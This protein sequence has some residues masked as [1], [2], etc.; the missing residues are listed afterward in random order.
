MLVLRLKAHTIF[1]MLFH[2]FYPLEP[3]DG[4]ARDINPVVIV[5]GLFGS[6]P[7]WRGFARKLA[8]TRAVYVVD[9]RNHGQSPKFDSNS[10]ADM[11]SDLLEFLDSQGLDK[12]VLI[13]HSMGGKVGF[14]FAAQYPERLEKLIVMDIAPVTYEHSHAPFVKALMSLDL[15]SLTSRSEADRL[16]KEA[17][18]ETGTRLF[19]LQS[20]QRENGEFVWQLNLPVLAEY[21]DDI[22]G[23]PAEQIQGKSYQ[24]ES[25]L[26]YGDK[27]DYVTEQHHQ[28]IRDILPNVS[29]QAIKDAG[30]WL[31]VEQADDVVAA[32]KRFL[33]KNVG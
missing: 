21:M 5:P 16:L 4:S 3:Q 13:G 17:I 6:T 8:T 31:H 29:I 10:Y 27:S 12:V 30:H 14:L 23:F 18:P 2:Q 1:S 33:E 24:G 19:L 11:V 20:L 25:L 9:Q 7:N 26:L 28:L 15:N 22:R 32:S